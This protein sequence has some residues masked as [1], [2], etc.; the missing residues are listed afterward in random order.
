MISDGELR[1]YL[2]HELP[3]SEANEVERSLEGD[4]YLRARLERLAAQSEDVAGLLGGLDAGPT[5]APDPH[6]AL[7][8]F[9]SG[10]ERPRPVWARP[11]WGALA[12][13]ILMAASLL[14]WP[15][16]RA[17]AQRLLGLLRFESVAVL[18]LDRRLLPGRLSESQ[19]QMFSQILTDSV[20]QL[21]RQQ[22]EENP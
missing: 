12:A 6:A 15:P 13:S 22:E 11:V 16:A 14:T 20:E 9:H 8:R 2:D 5:P 4:S 3:E 17:A 18:K 21:K 1:A 10:I 19:A 7:A